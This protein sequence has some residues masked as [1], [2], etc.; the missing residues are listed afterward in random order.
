MADFPRYA[1]YYAPDPG[2]ALDDFGASLLGYDARSA[3]DLPFPGDVTLIMPDWHDLTRDPRKYGFHATL[4]PPMALAEGRTEAELMAA[5]EAFA[6]ALRPVPLIEPIV[7][8][9]AG[10]IALLP[11]RRSAELQR[12][13]ADVTR[14]FDSFRAPL[15]PENR[16]RRNPEKLTPRQC[17]YL[18]RWGYPYVMEEFRFHL[19]LTRRLAAE[20]RARLEPELRQRTLPFAQAPLEISEISL[21]REAEPG[22]PLTIA[23]RFPF[24]SS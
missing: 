15:T 7:D 9:I 14:E 22:A 17:E 20:E 10:F 11:A 21:F 3:T 2:T 23:A 6:N 8:T 4:K 5:C 13:A 18:D 16:A 19:T 1:I 24:G 12:L